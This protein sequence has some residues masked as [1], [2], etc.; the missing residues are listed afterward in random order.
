MKWIYFLFCS[1][2]ITSGWAQPEKGDL[3]IA[4]ATVITITNGTL[5]NTDVL[6]KNGKIS[7]IGRAIKVSDNIKTIDATGKFIMPGIIDAHS[8]I[9]LDG[10]NESTNIITSEV[11]VG[12]V[13][14]PYD[15][16]IY[17][18]LAGG[19]TTSHVMHGSANPIGGECETI[20]H[21]YGLHNPN[22]LK[23]K[24]AP[25]TIKFALGENPI[26]IHGLGRGVVPRTRMGIEQVIRSA[27]NSAQQYLQAKT[28]YEKNRLSNNKLIPPLYNQRLE[29]LAD[30]LKGDI[31][32]HCHAYRAD[33]MIMLMEVFKDF[34]VEKICFQHAN[35]A[36]K[37][38]PE[39]KQFGAYA[40]VFSDWWAFKFETYYSTAYNAAML[41]KNGVPTS[42]NS[43]S[44]EVVRHLYHEA[45][46]AQRYGGLKDDEA[47]SLI[48][49]NAA[50]QLG[51]DQRVGSIEVGKDADFAMFSAHPLS[52][53][54]IPQ[55][56]IID[57][58]IYF[59][60]S[61]DA[62]DMRMGI[63]PENAVPT[64]A[65]ENKENHDHCLEGAE[66]KK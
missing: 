20:K 24:D 26:R 10:I 40:S 36:F 27:F 14:N 37:I 35:E 32:V 28:D 42:I 9:A 8:H 52:I 19:V 61:E 38:I 29:T 59:N 21:R 6:I 33:E 2:F 63:N 12:D 16:S 64:F 11:F 58:I 51:I 44:W 65:A 60:R 47:L 50:K 30:I 56:T 23:M 1:L 55:L 31:I 34:G 15:I 43:D 45:A 53:Y 49:I 46:K 25:R 41:T 3:L 17:R 5:T 62:L 54:A 18:A 7:R 39:L 13:I 66:H 4:N 57:G 48:T 22:D